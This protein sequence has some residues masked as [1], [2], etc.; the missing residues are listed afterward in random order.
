M[1]LV[2]VRWIVRVVVAMSP[3]MNS[4]AIDHGAKHFATLLGTILQETE[5]PIIIDTMVTG[6]SSAATG[7]MC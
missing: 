2:A 5:I 3:P 6:A 4:V 1:V 7:I